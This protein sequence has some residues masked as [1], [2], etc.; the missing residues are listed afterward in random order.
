MYRCFYY[1]I[2]IETSRFL[3]KSYMI[4]QFRYLGCGKGKGKK[5]KLSHYRPGKAQKVPG[6]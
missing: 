5:V 1:I 2:I 3:L 4:L 6:G